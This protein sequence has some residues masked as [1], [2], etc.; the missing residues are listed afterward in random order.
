MLETTLL[1]GCIMMIALLRS[2]PV[3]QEDASA[4]VS[5]ITV[6]RA[7][8]DQED[9]VKHESSTLVYAQMSNTLLLYYL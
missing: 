6:C 4:R 3:D 1:L 7:L 5:S 8:E 2:L 9:R